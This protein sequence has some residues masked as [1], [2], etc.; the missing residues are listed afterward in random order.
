MYRKEIERL[1]AEIRRLKCAEIDYY[2]AT[3][4]DSEL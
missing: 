4:D 1:E 2:L 3:G